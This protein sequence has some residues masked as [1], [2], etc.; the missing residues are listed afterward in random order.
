MDPNLLALDKA[1]SRRSVTKKASN[2]FWERVNGRAYEAL[3]VQRR[4]IT[5]TNMTPF[6]R[7]CKLIHQNTM[8]FTSL[9]NLDTIVDKDARVSQFSLWSLLV[10]S[11]ADVE[12][13]LVLLSNEDRTVRR[14]LCSQTLSP[15]SLQHEQLV[16]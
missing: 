2:R 5:S 10:L 4:P 7:I 14:S 11:A 6:Q 1:L 13:Q 8:L 3:R 12:E 9:G 15:H 16:P